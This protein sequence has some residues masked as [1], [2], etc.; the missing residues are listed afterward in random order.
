M[1]QTEFAEVWAY[2]SLYHNELF[3]RAVFR[4]HAPSHATHC[5]SLLG[6]QV[7]EKKHF[8]N[9]YIILNVTAATP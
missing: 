6:L 3:L 7:S 2:L 5:K 1:G 8:M 9:K 4:F